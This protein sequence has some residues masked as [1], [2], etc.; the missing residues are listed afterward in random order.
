LGLSLVEELQKSHFLV[1]KLFKNETNRFH[2]RQIYYGGLPF[3]PAEESREQ[4]AESSE[5]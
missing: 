5:F 2:T 1:F 4:R 3:S